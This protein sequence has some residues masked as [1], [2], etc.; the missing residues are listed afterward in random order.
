[1]GAFRGDRVERNPAFDW[2]L[3]ELQRL[4]LEWA[5]GTGGGGEVHRR[6]GAKRH[7]RSRRAGQQLHYPHQASL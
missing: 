4:R 3:V 2:A 1:M 6:A 5:D 7:C